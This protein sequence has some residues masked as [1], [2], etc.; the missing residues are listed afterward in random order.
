MFP[1]KQQNGAL[2]H[3]VPNSI[4]FS[5][6]YAIGLSA[7]K[8]QPCSQINLFC[9]AVGK[10]H[11]TRPYL[12][13]SSSLMIALSP[14]STKSSPSVLTSPLSPPPSL[15]ASPTGWCALSPALSA[16]RGVPSDAANGFLSE[17]PASAAW[18]SSPWIRGTSWGA[19]PSTSSGSASATYLQH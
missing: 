11:A 10:T 9:V 7:L 5:R 6:Q 12:S 3:G 2:Y 14:K 8:V 17:P 18:L 13:G 1:A 15:G 16:N 19:S 4:L